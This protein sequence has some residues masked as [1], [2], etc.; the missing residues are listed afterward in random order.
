M[1][2][3]GVLVYQMKRHACLRAKLT[4]ASIVIRSLPLGT[5]SRI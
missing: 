1:Q 5:Y 2:A 3:F 4:Y